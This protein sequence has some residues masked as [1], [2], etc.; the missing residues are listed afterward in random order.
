MDDISIEKARHDFV[1]TLQELAEDM[2]MT[3][4]QCKNAL[5]DTVV[6]LEPNFAPYV[7]LAGV[8]FMIDAQKKACLQT[9]RISACS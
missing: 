1:P 2:A 6:N 7:A 9:I 5:D 4:E 3:P 8:Q